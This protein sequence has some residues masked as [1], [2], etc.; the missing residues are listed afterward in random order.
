MLAYAR[1]MSRV[2][3][4]VTDAKKTRLNKANRIEDEPKQAKSLEYAI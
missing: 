2:Y 4:Q 3:I 1:S